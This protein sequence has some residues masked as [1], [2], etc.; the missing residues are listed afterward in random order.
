[1]KT[2]LLIV[3]LTAAFLGSP[4]KTTAGQKSDR[5]L[6]PNTGTML[7][8]SNAPFSSRDKQKKK[9]KKSRT[10]RS[11]KKM[12]Y[13]VL[14]GSP[15]LSYTVRK[16]GDG[17]RVMFSIRGGNTRIPATVTFE[18]SSGASYW[19]DNK[20]GYDNV[21]FPFECT[22]H[23]QVGYIQNP[24]NN[25]PSKLNDFHIIIYEPGIWEVSFNW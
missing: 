17:D 19:A 15:V 7:E 1:M 9:K 11:K 22:V 8:N 20:K 4:L 16:I 13:R 21:V 2:H 10:P 6:S 23:T 25:W 12:A 18:V 14:G 24:F 5:N 3:L